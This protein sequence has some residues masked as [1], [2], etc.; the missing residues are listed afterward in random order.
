MGAKNITD[1]ERRNI[2]K[3]HD[4]GFTKSDMVE[5]SG[6]SIFSVVKVMKQRPA[7]SKAPVILTETSPV[8]PNGIAPV[9]PESSLVEAFRAM[10]HQFQLMADMATQHMQEAILIEANQDAFDGMDRL[11]I[12]LREAIKEK[13][14][15]RNQLIQKATVVYSD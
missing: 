7:P 5:L 9:I 14:Q 15:L 4:E 2:W 6:R 10:A 3:W 8:S 1:E 11:K 13:E 12:S